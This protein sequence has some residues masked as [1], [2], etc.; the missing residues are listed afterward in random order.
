MVQQITTVWNNVRLKR[1]SDGLACTGTNVG[2]CMP[3]FYCSDTC[4]CFLRTNH[5]SVAH[6]HAATFN[7]PSHVA[8]VAKAVNI[9]HGKT[10]CQLGAGSWSWNTRKR[11][12]QG[13][14]FVPRHTFRT[15]GNI[16]PITGGS[17]NK[18]SG[19]QTKFAQKLVY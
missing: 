7:T 6:T 11:F 17:G 18:V 5:H 4:R 15:A 9:L 1:N 12:G 19:F 2:R 3:A 10:Q 13:W 8:F 14:A 16:I